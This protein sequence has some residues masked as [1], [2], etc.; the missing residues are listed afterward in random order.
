[1][2]RGVVGSGCRRS[3]RDSET[4]CRRDK[5]DKREQ[6]RGENEPAMHLQLLSVGPLMIGPMLATAA[7]TSLTRNRGAFVHATHGRAL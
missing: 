4:N 6:R 3:R 1:M 5:R 2:H 7:N